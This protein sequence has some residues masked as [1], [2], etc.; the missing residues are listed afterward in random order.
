LIGRKEF[1]LMKK[2]AFIINTSRGPVIDEKALVWALKT[3]QIAGAGIDVHE[4]EP[5]VNHS[6]HKLDNCILTPHVASATV[7]VREQMGLDAAHSI[8]AILKGKGKAKLVN[9]DYKKNKN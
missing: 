4:T 3:K 8:I 7:E 5:S 1:K 9:P 6:L 2:T